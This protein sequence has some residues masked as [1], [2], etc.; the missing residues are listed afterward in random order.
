[1]KWLKRLGGLDMDQGNCVQQTVD[2]G[3][4][5]AGTTWRRAN[6]RSDMYLTKTDS[7]GNVLWS[8]VFGGKGRDQGSEVQQTRDGGYVVVGE[9]ASRGAGSADVYL[10]KTDSTGRELWSKTFGGSKEDRGYSVQQTPDGGYVIAGE[11]KSFNGGKEEG[12]LVRTDSMGTLLWQRTFGGKERDWLQ[13]VRQSPG[14]GFVLAGSTESFGRGETD[15]YLIE[16]DPTG[17]PNWVRT[18]GDRYGEYGRSVRPTLD[19]GYIV[20]GY[21][22]PSGALGSTDAYLVKTDGR[23]QRMWDKRLGG[24]GFDY[25]YC[26]EQTLDGGYVIVGR[27]TSWGNQ[28]DKIYLIK[29]DSEGSVMWYK[30]YG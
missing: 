18:Y 6:H 2:M 9:T 5:I 16:T 19:G 22:W 24:V 12:F 8:R 27:S 29:T 14:G 13:S 20:A 30:I 11:S 28:S 1:M 15:I 10:V 7:E 25:G 23:G 3:Y 21:I 17:N 26:V 4:V